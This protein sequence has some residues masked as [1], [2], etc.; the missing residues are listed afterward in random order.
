MGWPDINNKGVRIINTQDRFYKKDF[1]DLISCR[2]SLTFR[3]PKL[4]K[5]N[6][7]Y[8]KLTRQ[9]TKVPL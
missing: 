7:F 2:S 6:F 8:K 9:M 3:I 4:A 5:I 1:P